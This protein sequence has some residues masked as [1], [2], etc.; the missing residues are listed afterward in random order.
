MALVITKT[1]RMGTKMSKL[2]CPCGKELNNIV[3]PNP[4]GYYML[5]DSDV[6]SIYVATSSGKAADLV[7]ELAH[8]VWKCPQCK[9]IAIFH[10]LDTGLTWYVVE[11]CFNPDNPN[12]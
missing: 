8:E 9:R 10:K 2:I 6:D 1:L 7:T 5:S 11:S 4:N 12:I 3:S